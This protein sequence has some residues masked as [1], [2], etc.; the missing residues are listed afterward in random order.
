MQMTIMNFIQ[1]S[2]LFHTHLIGITLNGGAVGRAGWRAVFPIRKHEFAAGWRAA[3]KGELAGCT[4]E[5][6]A[7][8]TKGRAAQQSG[9]AGCTKERTGGLH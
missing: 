9:P 2:G 1:T 8:C 7:G 4:T 5:R 6:P 3:L